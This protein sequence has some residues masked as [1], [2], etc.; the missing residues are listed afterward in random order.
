MWSSAGLLVLLALLLLLLLLL[1]ALGGGGRSEA[2]FA[3]RAWRGRRRALRE[4][5]SLAQRFGRAARGRASRVFLRCEGRSFTYGQAERESNRVAQALRGGAGGVGGP[6]EPGQTVALLMGNEPAFVWAWI[7]LAKLGVLPA[8]LGTALRRGALLHCLRSCG[9]RALLAAHD[10]FEAVEPILPDLEEMG[11]AVWVLG[12][13]PYP[14]GVTALDN[15]LEK[16]SDDPVPYDLATPGDLSDTCL[17]IFTSGTTGLPKAAR[18]SH[19]K[20]LLCLEFYHLVGGTSSDVIYVALPLYHLAGALLGIVGTFGLGATC[21]L[22]KKFSASQ[23]WP[24][25]RHYGVTVFQYIGELCRYL[26]NQP[27][28][29]RDREH[30]LRMAVGSGLRADVWR[31][32]IRRF[33]DMQIFETYGMTEGSVTFF[34]ITGAVGA[35]GRASWLYKR[36]FPFELLRYDVLQGAPLRDEAGWCQRVKTGEPGLLVA[37]VTPMT[38]FLGYAGKRE[39]SE[40]KLLRNVFADGDVYF[41]TGDLMLQDTHG[42][43]YFWDRTGD[44][45]RWKGE[46]VATTEVSEILATLE[47]FQHVNVYGVT[48]PGHEGRA[49]MATVVLRPGREFNGTEVYAHAAE[50]LPPFA[51]PRFLR[52]QEHL[53]MT[54]T[55]K[56]KKVRL[57]A[58]GF[59]PTHIT[60]PLFFLDDGAKT[61]AP[62]TQPIWEGIVA[63]DI[64]L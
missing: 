46:N 28:S 59:D 52:I 7:G 47:S 43:I 22:K 60:E 49:G 54:D 23:F 8:F 29:P 11:V 2:A 58:E 39:L 37:P 61:Y 18:V 45:F 15:L 31:E 36:M 34:N 16:A 53:E 1:A 20:C 41:N 44:T 33:G 6:L 48:V 63:G 32:F 27:Q 35:V 51:R 55:F 24:D 4:R 12:K 50:L 64:R 21:V 26:V 25:C 17:Y 19:M 56:Q 3:L 30:S 57:A 13:G 62:L 14:A 5:S 40:A 10:L 42:F 38:P 9:A